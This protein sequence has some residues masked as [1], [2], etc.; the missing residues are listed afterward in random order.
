M[1]TT[2]SPAGLRAAC[3]MAVLFLL[4][5]CNGD[6]VFL[7]AQEK[8]TQ[9][10]ESAERDLRSEHEEPDVPTI[11][12]NF[13]HASGEQRTQLQGIIECYVKQFDET[14]RPKEVCLEDYTAIAAARPRTKDEREMIRHYF[15][16]LSNRIEG[17]RYKDGE[18]AVI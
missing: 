15:G 4:C 7:Q 10:S 2:S 6:D 3:G 1:N 5:A 17:D 18:E 16:S 8:H 13:N 14:K 11:V 9:P 12:D